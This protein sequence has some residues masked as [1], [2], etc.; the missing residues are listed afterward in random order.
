MRNL[1]PWPLPN[2]GGF[3]NI[4]QRLPLLR[5]ERQTPQQIVCRLAVDDIRLDIEKV[6]PCGLLITELLS[7]AYKHAFADGRAGQIVISMKQVADLVDLEV[8]DN[9]LGLPAGFDYRQARTLG[10]QLIMALVNQLNG[11]FELQSDNGVRFS[12]RFAP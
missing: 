4:I 2:H 8:V 11:V 5:G 6:V 1:R 3:L 9:G 10:L 12:L 7:N